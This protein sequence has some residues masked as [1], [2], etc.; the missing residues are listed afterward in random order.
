M[1]CIFYLSFKNRFGVLMEQKGSEYLISS[2]KLSSPRSWMQCLFLSKLIKHFNQRGFLFSFKA[3]VVKVF[4]LKK[5]YQFLGWWDQKIVNITI[6][7]EILYKRSLSAVLPACSD[8]FVIIW[9]VVYLSPF[10]LEVTSGGRSLHMSHWSRSG[11]VW[12]SPLL[13]SDEPLCHPSWRQC[14][15]N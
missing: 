4:R 11:M 2:S 15:R 14:R 12:P 9:E 6:K 1:F 10:W 7:L 5:G 3:L 13:E 8:P